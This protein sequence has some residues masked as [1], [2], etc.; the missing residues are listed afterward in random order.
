MITQRVCS[1]PALWG[2]RLA[3][4]PPFNFERPVQRKLAGPFRR[5]AGIRPA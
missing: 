2:P 5:I 4:Y 1:L 3:P